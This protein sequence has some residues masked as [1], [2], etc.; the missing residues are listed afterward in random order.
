MDESITTNSPEAKPSEGM[1]RKDT[2]EPQTTP[3]AD[4]ASPESDALLS[5]EQLKE[6][7]SPKSQKTQGYKKRRKLY[8]ALARVEASLKVKDDDLVLVTKGDKAEFLVA[9]IGGPRTAIRLLKRAA[10]RRQ[11][12]YS[13][14]PEQK[15]VRINNFNVELETVNPDAPPIDQMFVSGK[16]ASKEEGAFFVDIGRNRRT[17]RAK[18]QIKM[19]L[20]IEGLEANPE[21]NLGQWVGLIL[22]RQGT[23]W[24]WRGDTRAVLKSGTSKK[25]DNPDQTSELSPTL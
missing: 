20:K 6:P 25:Q 5:D 13:L 10:N 14:Y 11:G 19:P 2:I 7:D 23:K 8:Q 24:V 22:H 21:W 16:L 12:F 1:V 18:K 17:I 4:V 9:Q 15:A 3:A